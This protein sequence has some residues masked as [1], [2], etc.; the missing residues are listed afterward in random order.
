MSAICCY[1][2]PLPALLSLMSAGLLPLM[3]AIIGV[4]DIAAVLSIIADA[5]ASLV[6]CVLT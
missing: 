1:I 5:G 6:R 4:F 3:S 2:S